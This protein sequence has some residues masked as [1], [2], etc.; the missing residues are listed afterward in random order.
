M[1]QEDTT[2]KKTIKARKDLMKAY[3]TN[4]PK[5]LTHIG[6]SKKTHLY[7]IKCNE[8]YKI[9]VSTELPDRLSNI[10][11]H[12][13]YDVSIVFA[14]EVPQGFAY[15]VESLFHSLFAAKK[16]RGEWFLLNDVDLNTIKELCLM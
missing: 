2:A 7:V 3:H 12:N 16:H 13:P 5:L 14:Y 11:V 15:E 6:E 10:K 1:A 8:F 9:G 4:L